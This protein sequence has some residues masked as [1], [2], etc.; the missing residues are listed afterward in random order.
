MVCAP[1]R[2]TLQSAMFRSKK[3]TETSLKA[4]LDY[5]YHQGEGNLDDNWSGNDKQFF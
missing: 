3:K 1:C 4:I 5:S 2:G